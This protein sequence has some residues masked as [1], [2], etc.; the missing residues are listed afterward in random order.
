MIG[1]NSTSKIPICF[2]LIFELNRV[3]SSVFFGFKHRW[4]ILNIS[5]NDVI[6]F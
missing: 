6:Q 4:R 2:N 3:E 5:E 1:F